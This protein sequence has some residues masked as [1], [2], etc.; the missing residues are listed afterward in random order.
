MATTAPDDAGANA[1]ILEDLPQGVRETMAERDAWLATLPRA[2]SG[3]EFLVADLQRWAPGQTVRVAFLGGSTELHRDIADATLQITDACNLQLDFGF[4]PATGSFRTWSTADTAYAAE[5]RVSFDQG[6]YFSLVGTD[7]IDAAIGRPFDPVGGRPHQRSLNLGGYDV[8]RPADWRGTT[9]H[10][11]LHALAF[12]H[13]HQNLNGPCQDEFRWD[14][15]PGY[16]RT[17]DA[18]GVFINDAQGRRPGI[19]TYLSGAPNRWDRAKVDH[20]LRAHAHG[21]NTAGAFDPASVMLYRFPPLFY[22]QAPSPCAPAGNGQDLSDG[23][24]AGL[25]LLYPGAAP[26]NL[27]R[28]IELLQV[29][30]AASPMES[31]AIEVPDAAG[32]QAA[33]AA[34]VLRATLARP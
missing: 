33:G 9:R 5:I 24:R 28:R 2:S 12:H 34:S 29:L 11:F 15:D 25:R 17:Q 18:R 10:E 14:D 19:Y 23:D 20:N 8:R 22:R 26:A 31:L 13:E 16:A 4:D 27:A 32:R 3:E 30:E 21:E 1:F 6:G 7:S